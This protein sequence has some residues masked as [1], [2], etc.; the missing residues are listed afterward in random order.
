MAHFREFPVKKMWAVLSAGTPG[1]CCREKGATRPG[2]NLEI[3]RANRRVFD[4]SRATYGSPRIYCALQQRE[5]IRSYAQPG[6]CSLEEETIR[7]N[8]LLETRFAVSETG[9][10]WEI[11]R[12]FRWVLIEKGLIFQFGGESICESGI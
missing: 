4:G 10:G 9:R 8:N 11:F 5:V 6:Y 2:E 12:T 7:S 1:Y 3:R